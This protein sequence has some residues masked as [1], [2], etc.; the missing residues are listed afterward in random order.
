MDSVK[1]TIEASEADQELLIA[2]LIDL[3]IA[4]FEQLEDELIAWFNVDEFDESVIIPILSSYEYQTERIKE[5]NWN[6]Q[7]EKDFQPVIVN[8]FCAIR[9][10]F[11]A[12]ISSV[13]HEIIITPKM[14]FG[15]GH[16]ATTHMMIQHMEH[17]DFKNKTVFDFGTG[18]GILAIL[19]EQLGAKAILAIDLD[20]WSI[21]N[22]QEN[23]SRNNCR[24]IDVFQGSQVPDG[25]AFDVIL[26]N[27]NKNVILQHLKFLVPA[28]NDHGTILFSGL[29]TDDE[30]DIVDACKGFPL[31]LIRKFNR[32]N[33]ISLYFSKTS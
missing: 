31:T 4:G 8:D 24:L 7:W 11:H 17:I 12:P 33:W 15:T 25:K 10:H 2:I 3:N 9:A 28:I 20:E 23:I 30:V 5:K 18:T 29:L 16:H 6:E 1:I 14:S 32:G 21:N 22:A 13:Q 26:A 19:A 27:I